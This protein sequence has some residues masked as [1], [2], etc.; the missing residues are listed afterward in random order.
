MVTLSDLLLF[1]IS[2]VMMVAIVMMVVISF[3]NK[4]RFLEVCRLYEAEFGSLPLAAAVLKDADV[5]GFTAG[6]STKINFIIH[7]LIYG[8]KSA[9]SKIDDAAFI[10]GLPANIRY[11]FI[12]EFVCSAIGFVA[13][14]L[15]GVWLWVNK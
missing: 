7:P 14:L 4:K 3:L 13:L 1:I 8:K 6:Y 11:W 15:G 5:I 9:H 10:R 12:A 2:G